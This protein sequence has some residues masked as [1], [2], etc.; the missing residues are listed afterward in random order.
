MKAFKIIITKDNGEVTSLNLEGKTLEVFQ[1]VFEDKEFR[2]RLDILYPK[3]VDKIGD[4]LSRL[5]FESLV[6]AFKNL[7]S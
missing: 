4:E 5:D 6:Y 2:D 7:Q 3:F 1:E